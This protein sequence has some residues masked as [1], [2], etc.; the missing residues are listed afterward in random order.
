MYWR[1]ASVGHHLR[2]SSTDSACSSTNSPGPFISIRIFF[3]ATG[4]E[5]I[6]LIE[7]SKE[8]MPCS[9]VEGRGKY[10]GTTALEKFVV[11][12][13]IFVFKLWRES[14][15]PWTANMVCIP[16]QQGSISIFFLPV[17]DLGIQMVG[18]VISQIQFTPKRIGVCA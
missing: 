3:I 6:T 9:Y 13:K 10:L 16:S 8:V 7:G 4:L 2:A 17:S 14:V 12:V 11:T 15:C 18:T 5:L 1:F